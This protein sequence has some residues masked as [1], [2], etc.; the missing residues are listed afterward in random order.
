MVFTYCT[1]TNYN[2][3][4]N[5]ITRQYRLSHDGSAGFYLRSISYGTAAPSGG[6][7]GDMYLQV[8]S[9]TNVKSSI[10]DIV[11]PVGS[12]YMSVNSTSP[13]SLFG[14]TWSQLKDRFL[15]ACGDTYSNGATGGEA[16]H[17]LTV[18]EM[19]AHTHT[20][21]VYNTDGHY[22]GSMHETRAWSDTSGTSELQITNS[23]GGNGAH[24]NMPPY[25][26]VYIWKRTA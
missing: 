21:K 23:V 13:A 14:G 17:K 9:A 22:S 19:P 15:L 7:T 8:A 24:N 5:N 2:A 1:D 16:T 18:A 3:N 10:I 6:S 11:Y 12:I 4:T 25:L 20:G 26:A